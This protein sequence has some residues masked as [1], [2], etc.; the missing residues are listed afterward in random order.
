MIRFLRWFFGRP[1]PTRIEALRALLRG[2][3]N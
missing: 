2:R 3:E 1:E